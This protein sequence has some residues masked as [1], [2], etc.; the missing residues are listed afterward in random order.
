MCVKQ[1][2]RKGKRFLLIDDQERVLGRDGVWIF[3]LS[4][5]GRVW[6]PQ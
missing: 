6:A 2:V 5:L 3:F 1:V 4:I